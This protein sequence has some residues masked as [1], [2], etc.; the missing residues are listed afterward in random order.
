MPQG[1]PMDGTD[2][3]AKKPV[4]TA[5]TL[6]H[7][8]MTTESVKRVVIAT[9]KVFCVTVGILLSSSKHGSVSK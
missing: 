5:E 4:G 7:V 6:Q 2:K 3:T 1:V 9:M 8:A